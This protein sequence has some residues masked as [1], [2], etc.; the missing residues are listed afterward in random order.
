M[1]HFTKSNQYANTLTDH[2]MKS[3]RRLDLIQN[4]QDKHGLEFV[5][6]PIG[7]RRFAK[8][9]AKGSLDSIETVIMSSSSLR[10]P[11]NELWTMNL[12]ALKGL[13]ELQFELYYTGKWKRMP[14]ILLPQVERLLINV[15]VRF[16]LPHTPKSI[17]YE[18]LAGF[19]ESLPNLQS[20]KLIGVHFDSRSVE[21]LNRSAKKK[22]LNS[23]TTLEIGHPFGFLSKLADVH[24][25]RQRTVF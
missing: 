9:A 11:N 17:T 22:K 5:S 6:V 7:V 24:L 10:K 13:R 1:P 3:C 14:E 19:I 21:R 16:L 8:F 12:P 4:A 25:G 20:L 2:I 15:D 18:Q 23:L